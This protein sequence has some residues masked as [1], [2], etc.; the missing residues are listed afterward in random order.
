MNIS[1]IISIISSLK[2]NDYQLV[3]TKNNSLVIFKS[4]YKYTDCIYI[5]IRNKEAQIRYER[6]FDNKYVNYSIERLLIF[7]KTVNSIDEVVSLIKLI[8]NKKKAI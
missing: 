6:V 4:K 2:L 7:N 3:R 8:C 5:D 1:K